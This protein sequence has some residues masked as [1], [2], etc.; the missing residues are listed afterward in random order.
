MCRSSEERNASV[1]FQGRELS[2][3]VC[4]LLE[5]GVHKSTGFR[6]IRLQIQILGFSG[7]LGPGIC[8]YLQAQI[9][10]GGVG[11]P[12]TLRQ[13]SEELEGITQA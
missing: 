7:V 8:V 6:V 5:K 12:K 1:P 11:A 9:K 10:W 3:Q 13:W 2:N 4:S